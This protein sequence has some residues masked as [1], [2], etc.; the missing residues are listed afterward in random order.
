MSS[1]FTDVV[2]NPAKKTPP[3]YGRLAGTKNKTHSTIRWG[4]VEA[5]RQLG[6]VD[7]LVRWGQS[8]PDLFYPL[9]AKLIPAEMAEAGLGQDN[10][11]QVVIVPAPQI[12]DQNQTLPLISPS[13]TLDRPEVIDSSPVLPSS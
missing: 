11:I 7:G 4:L 9:L 8:N 12:P 5:Y 2:N 3:R 1:Y 10:R 6:G 13:Q